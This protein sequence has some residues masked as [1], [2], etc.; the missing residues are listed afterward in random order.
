MRYYVV[1]ITNKRYYMIGET[2]HSSMCLSLH[3]MYAQTVYNVT[4]GS[5]ITS[6]STQ[7]AG[8]TQAVQGT[9]G[10]TD[11]GLA[12]GAQIY[13]KVSSNCHVLKFKLIHLYQAIQTSYLGLWS[14]IQT[15]TDMEIKRTALVKHICVFLQFLSF[16]CLSWIGTRPWSSTW[17][18]P[19]I[20]RCTGSTSLR[21]RT[22]RGQICG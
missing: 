22:R 8:A 1:S 13:A 3:H 7:S 20:W 21:S 11:P 10:R 6:L 2:Q 16:L 4:N 18:L 12:R 9:V 17:R 19:R 5:L 14:H 15:Y